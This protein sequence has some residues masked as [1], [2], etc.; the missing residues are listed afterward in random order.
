MNID[1]KTKPM[2]PIAGDVIVSPAPPNTRWRVMEDGQTIR[3]Q[4]LAIPYGGSVKIKS[5]FGSVG[6]ISRQSPR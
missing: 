1:H 4:N 6:R 5:T 3:M 2:K